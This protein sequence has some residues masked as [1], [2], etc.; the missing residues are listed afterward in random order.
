MEQ[1]DHKKLVDL[2]M[3]MFK[4]NLREK[5]NIKLPT[6]FDD[7]NEEFSEDKIKAEEKAKGP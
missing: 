7:E 4:S 5:Y 6:K 3:D 1:A 2:K